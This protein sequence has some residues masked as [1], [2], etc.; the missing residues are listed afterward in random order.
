MNILFEN[1]G[2]NCH[3]DARW[4]PR[5]LGIG[6]NLSLNHADSSIGIFPKLVREAEMLANWLQNGSG[7]G[8]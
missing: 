1:L 3:D 5:K 6:V 2:S 7:K 4:E 8:K